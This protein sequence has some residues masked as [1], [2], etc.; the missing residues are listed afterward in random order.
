[1]KVS[2]FLA[3]KELGYCYKRGEAAELK[4]GEKIEE[5][6]EERFGSFGEGKANKRG[7]HFGLERRTVNRKER[8]AL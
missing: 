3:T 7:C 5:R 1:M 2:L 6:R 8:K 4:R